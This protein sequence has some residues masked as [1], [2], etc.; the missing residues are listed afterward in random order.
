VFQDWK[1]WAEE[2]IID[3]IIPMAYKRE[4]VPRERAQFDDWITFSKHLGARTRRHVVIG[5]GSYLNSDKGTLAQARRART[6][7]ADGVIV[8]AL[9]KKDPETARAKL[10]PAFATPASIPPMPWKKSL[11]NLMGIAKRDDGTP[12]DSADVVIVD[13]A[14]GAKRKSITDG[15]GFFGAAGLQPGNY[16]VEVTLGAE[17]LTF[18]PVS[19]KAATVAIAQ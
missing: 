15:G 2:G 14:S 4:H 6:Q 19:V 9:G 12:L 17:S 18:G 1:S 5:L 11:G 7:P 8:F 10:R 13:I 16:R 3:V